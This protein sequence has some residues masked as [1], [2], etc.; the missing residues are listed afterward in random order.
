MKLPAT[1]TVAALYVAATFAIGAVAG[2]AVSYAYGRKQPPRRFDPEAMRQQQKE[3]YAKELGLSPAQIQQLDQILRQ[4]M[5]EFGV[6][7]REH[8]DRVHDLMKRGQERI[9]GILTPEQ[10]V[11]FLEMEKKREEKFARDG[12]GDRRGPPPEPG[13][14]PP[15]PK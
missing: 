2:G 8:M 5:D 11:E 14:P 13:G 3:R 9:A 7:H 12:R 1:R 6:C 15:A 4:G 10:K